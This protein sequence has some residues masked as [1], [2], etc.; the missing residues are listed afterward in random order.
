MN[1]PEL[2]IQN[3]AIDDGDIYVID[4]VTA[5]LDNGR[6][7]RRRVIDLHWS[8]IVRLQMERYENE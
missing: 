3:Y 2:T 1:D 5:L 6:Y 4:R 8:I 7:V